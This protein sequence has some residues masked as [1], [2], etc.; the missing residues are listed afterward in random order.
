LLGSLAAAIARVPLRVVTL[1]GA[2]AGWLRHSRAVTLSGR[3]IGRLATAV[4][5]VSEEERRVAIA[6]GAA[7]PGRAVV[8]HNA[9]DVASLPR[10][11]ER[12]GAVRLI[13]VGRMRPPKDFVTLT[14]A[15]AGLPAASFH[16]QIVGDGP[17]RPALEA[18]LAA[19]TLNGELELTGE[20][21]DVPELLAESDA[22]VLS[23]RSEGLPLSVLEAMA[24]G[25]PVVA[26]AVGGVPELVEDGLTGFLVPAGDEDAMRDRL[27]QLVA[28][29]DLRRSMGLAAR[30]RAERLFDLPAMRQAHVELYERLLAGSRP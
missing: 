21:S 13:S 28:D 10:R 12:N 8:I 4:V 7:R 29:P 22:F 17:D 18:E 27:A 11:R 24:V 9:V 15:L 23:S 25:L 5:C 26:T 20:R 6:T 1:N 14:R 2:V 30:A 3:L 19:S 16:A